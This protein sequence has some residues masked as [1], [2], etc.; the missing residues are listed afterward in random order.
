M[1]GEVMCDYDCLAFRIVSIYRVVYILASS[2]KDE[3]EKAPA[4]D[5][6]QSGG[7]L[8]RYLG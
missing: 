8:W 7:K 2:S 1:T 3:L 6:G 5:G 4:E